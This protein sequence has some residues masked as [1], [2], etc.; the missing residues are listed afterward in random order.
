[1]TDQHKLEEFAEDLA[2]ENSLGSHSWKMER[3][4]DVCVINP[5]SINDGF[6]YDEMKYLNI[7]ST[8]KGY[9]QEYQHHNI[10]DAPSRA[11]RTVEAGD[12]VISTVRPGRE[13][14]VYM[15][16]PDEN[17]VV[18]TGFVVLRPKNTNELDSRFLYYAVTRPELIRY[19]ESNATGSAYPAVNLSVVRDGKI[20]IPPIDKQ[21]KIAN[22]LSNLDE[23]I[24]INNRISETLEDFIRTIF[25]SWFVDFDPYNEFKDSRN[26]RVPINF[27]VEDLTAIANVTYGYGFNSDDFNEEKKGY[28]VI[29]NGD[30]PNPTIEY[31]TSKYIDKNIDSKYEVSPGDLVVT[32]DRYFDPYLW[33]GK[34]AALNQR[35]CKFEGRSEEFSNILLYN[36][37]RNPI[38]KIEQAKT[39]TTLPHLGKSDI[40]NI[41]VVVPDSGSLSR[42]NNMA[43]PMYEKIVNLSK[44]NRNL[45]NLRDILLPKLMSCEV[46]LNPVI[47]NNSM[48]DN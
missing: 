40:D 8:G 9:I 48:S 26:R 5:S 13:Q 22:A 6:G 37:I 16:D 38:N 45:A 23:K 19:F 36:L 27:E 30:L 10:D 31:E 42:F 18:S 7:S 47:N 21:K 33:K 25:K 4:E 14:Y 28:P 34:T 11:K 29:R 46:R 39:G 12:S 2:G 15:S 3:I 43:L 35:I 32:M 20:P 17:V 41:E 44:E 1:M 24:A